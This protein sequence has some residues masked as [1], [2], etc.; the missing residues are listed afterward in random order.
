MRGRARQSAAVSYHVEIPHLVAI[1]LNSFQWFLDEGLRELFHNFSPIEDFTG[2]LKLELVDYTLG[3]PKYSVEECRERDA[4]YEAPIHVKV[5]LQSSK[6]D[7]LES[8]VYLGD[9]PLMTER[10]TFL[11]NGAERVV[12]SQLARSPGVY[13]KEQ[14]D[15]SGRMLY[16]ATII[17]SEGAWIEIDSDPSDA[18]WVRIGQTPKFPVTALLRALNIFPA[19]VPGSREV[20]PVPELAGRIVTEQITDTMTG[21]ILADPWTTVTR[22]LAE[23]IA[24][25][26][27]D[28]DAY[29]VVV[30]YSTTQQIIDLFSEEEIVQN[31]VKENLTGKRAGEDIVD[32]ET[33]KTLVSAY[34]LIDKDTARKI[35]ALSLGSVRLLKVNRYVEGTLEQDPSTNA[36]EALLHIYR[37]IRPGDPPTVESAKGLLN[38]IFFD[39]RRYDLQRVGRHK[40]NRK[41]GLDVPN[42]TRGITRDDLI[43]I[44]RYMANLSEGIGGPDDIDHLENKRVRSVGELLQNQLRLG[45]LRMEKVARERMTS[46]DA[47]NAIP[48]VILSVKPISAS[49]KSFFGSSQ[50]SQFMDQTNPLA[51]LTHKRRISALGPG[52]LSR[53]SAKLEVR[54]VHH[55]HYGRICPIETPEGPNIGLIGSLAVMARIN[56]FGF[57]EAAYRKVVKGKVTDEVVYIT[58]DEEEEHYIAP[59]NAPMNPDGTFAAPLIQVRNRGTFPSVSPD[60][61]SYMDVAPMQIVSPATAMIPFLE[62][63]DANRALMG[64]NMQRQAVPLLRPQ[65]PLVGTGLEERAARDSGTIEVAKRAGTVV[66]VTSNQIDIRTDDGII[67]SY[68]LIN[69]LRSNQ[70]TCITQ[71]PIVHTGQRVREK[72]VIA[73]GPC[74]EN[75]ELALGKNVVVAF[76]P[77]CGYN[78]ED[79]VLLSERVVKDDIFTSIHIEKYETEA[80]DTKLGP[81]EITRDIP[82]VGEDA[83]KDLDENGI[84]RIGAEVHPEDIL[85]GK[86][87]PKGQGELSAEERLVIAI[88]GKKAEETRDV[89]LRVPHGETGKI[90]DVKVFSRFKYSCSRCK[91]VYNFS[92]KPE[93]ST[94]ES[95]DGELIREP[96]DELPA[97]VNELVR[98]YIAQK[99]KIMAGD[100]MAGRHGNKG[101]VSRIL[102]ESDMPYLADGTPVDIV[103]NPLGVPS[104]MNIGQIMETHLGLAAKLAGI[105]YENPI[106]QGRKENEILEELRKAA[107]PL[108][109]KVL[110]RYLRSELELE[111]PLDPKEHWDVACKAVKDHIAELPQ[112][113]V[114]QLS[115]YLGL[116]EIPQDP[117]AVVVNDRDELAQTIL[118]NARKRFGLNEKTAKSIVYDGRTGEPFNQS[119]TVGVIYMLKLIHLVEDKIHARSTGPYSM[120][121][122][123]P[124]GGKAQ[125][126]GQRFGEMEVWALEAY[127]A[128]S[129]LQEML[130]IKSDD[131][132]GRVK[133]YESIVKGDQIL[134]PGIPES[135]KI[136]INELRSLGLKVV[137][138]DEHNNP[139]DLRDTDDD[140][141]DLPKE[142][143]RVIPSGQDTDLITE[144]KEEI[145]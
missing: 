71:R 68:H 12:V 37:K 60:K 117:D 113:R 142:P 21:E 107:Q 13:F 54:D 138:E 30:E 18:V 63:D 51:E 109:I 44:I 94:C 48:Q 67:D 137:V 27:P 17:P 80:R 56:E 111:I 78:Y 133:T 114:D 88:F 130:T 86:V 41:L 11:I 118:D 5:R 53:Q 39:Q 128:S 131:V 28:K 16:F 42:S 101:V 69:M 79:A 122:Q 24:K 74:T 33:G 9:L 73:D 141:P 34:T 84:I 77:W 61:I 100:K 136:L 115:E 123:Q 87:A 50:L 96:G 89:S 83:L 99:R 15:V 90:V 31:V 127:G 26:V 8:E 52:G 36:N 125:F 124:L 95:C 105:A 46:L 47:E 14:M 1:Q 75:G 110:D 120:I 103:L 38:S 72:E 10:G 70:A 59:A 25:T 3:D 143:S 121:T 58:A 91:R 43:A 116:G 66:G 82:N 97:G 106:F 40:M 119:V 29:E 76:M 64:S 62:N 57:L 144:P 32:P 20:V 102:P 35:E 19:A 93:H 55:S 129:I 145:S 140:T 7:V 4:T 23:K 81:E 49:I 104:R 45:F 135:F 22:D 65:A 134:E 98:V 112:E 85:V 132:L 92:K 108:L 126:G 2:N 6:R 139:I